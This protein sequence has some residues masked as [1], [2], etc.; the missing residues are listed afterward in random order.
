MSLLTFHK[1]EKIILQK[2]N[3]FEGTFEFKPLEPG[4]GATIG[5][6]LRRVLPKVRPNPRSSGSAIITA[7]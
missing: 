3:E 2:A 4:Y 1:P 6:A 7:T 5:N